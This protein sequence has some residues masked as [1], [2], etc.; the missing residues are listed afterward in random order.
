MRVYSDKIALLKNSRGVYS[1]DTVM[2]C[3][4]GMNYRR[5]GCFGECFAAKSAKLY[6]YDFSTNVLRNFTGNNHKIKI[7][8]QINSIPAAFIRIGSSGDPSGDWEHTAKICEQIKQCTKEIVIITKHWNN[9][10]GELLSVFESAKVTFNTSVSALDTEEI[11][12]NCLAQH[13][14]ISKHCKSFIRVVSCDFNTDNKEGVRLFEVQKRLF[15]IPNVI[16]TI[17]R[18]NKNN[19]L[20]K[21][22]VINIQQ[23][24]FLGKNTFV[25]RYKKSTYFGKCSTCSELCG[26]NMTSNTHGKHQKEVQTKMFKLKSKV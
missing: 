15:E 19:P 13:E 10:T 20:A 16:D 4:A 21:E 26:A 8:R 7:I 11:T 17:L 12:N 23:E 25:S 22:G 9:I 2:G 5:G 24:S 1:L 14:R 18:V 6:G 3:N